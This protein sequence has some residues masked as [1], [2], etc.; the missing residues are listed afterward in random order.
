VKFRVG[1]V[2]AISF[3]DLR[4][5]PGD[6]EPRVHDLRIAECLEFKQPFQIRELIKRNSSELERFGN[7][8]YGTIKSGERGRPSTDFWL[9]EAQ[10]ILICMRSD[11]P[12]AADVRAD[13]ITIFQAWRRGE[14]VSPVNLPT[15]TGAISDLFE[16]FE[17]KVVPVLQDLRKEIKGVAG[18]VTILAAKGR[19]E[20]A[21]DTYRV[22]GIVIH[23]H[24]FDRCP[25]GECETK[26]MDCDGFISGEWEYHHQ[27]NR[28]DNRAEA[29][30]P[31]GKQCHLRITTNADARTRFDMTAFP[32]FQKL[33][34]RLP[35]RQSTFQF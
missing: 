3:G 31:L 20:P 24:Y 21:P 14:L 32:Q 28:H 23:H 29:T 18:N 7:L 15:I 25:C 12:R 1:N 35:T 19:R 22:H 9:T 33:L 10:A 30:I 2:L 11:A 13:L 26:I 27:F 8:S 5:I 17:Q 34:S 6:A 4:V 16:K